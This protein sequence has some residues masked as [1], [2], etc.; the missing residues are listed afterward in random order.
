MCAVHSSDELLSVRRALTTLELLAGAPRGRGVSDLARE[1]GVHKSSASRLLATLR[2]GGLVDIDLATGRFE[3][4]AG[5]LRLAAR[6]VERLDISQ[7]ALP[8]L[9]D[10]AEH[11]GETAYLSV[12]R[13]LYRVAV[14]EVESTN[15]VRMV[16]GVGHPY[17]LYRGAP[18][19]ILLAALPDDEIA[20]VLGTMPRDTAVRRL[21]TELRKEIALTRHD[22][23]A[24][25]L[26]ENVAS[27]AA[28]AVPILGHLG[29]VVAALG[30]A[31]VT[32]RWNRQ[33]MLSFLPILRQS[34][35][36]IAELIGHPL[37]GGES[38]TSVRKE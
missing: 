11:S 13:G 8:F 6:A 1:L 10:L 2:S 16:A 36:E 34:A 28:V 30:V 9:R 21:K 22:G 32:P 19:K 35:H 15:P 38:A 29:N 4:G 12:R 17:P 31:G 24:I 7:L 37:S 18:S 5:F 14:Q 3:L 20:K 33:R 23:Y 26:E 27:A 25:S